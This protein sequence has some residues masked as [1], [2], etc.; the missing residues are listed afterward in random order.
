[1][2]AISV[3]IDT[4]KGLARQIQRKIDDRDWFSE[5]V[6]E[7]QGDKEI[8]VYASYSLHFDDIDLDLRIYRPR[9]IDAANNEYDIQLEPAEIMAYI[10]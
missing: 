4:I 2:E 6:Y 9:A 10:S 5:D 7:S 8:A 3:D 1:M